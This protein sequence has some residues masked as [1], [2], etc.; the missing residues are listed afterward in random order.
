MQS[1]SLS[2]PASSGCT[3]PRKRKLGW[4]DRWIFPLVSRD[5]LS[6]LLSQLPAA[7]S[8]L[9]PIAFPRRFQDV[10]AVRRPVQGGSANRWIF[11]RAGEGHPTIG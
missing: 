2:T 3:R 9:Q 11:R 7:A 4:W 10:A 8:V 1:R 6:F 5:L